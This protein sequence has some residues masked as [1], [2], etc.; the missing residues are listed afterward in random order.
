M[1]NKTTF[2]KQKSS[3][4]ESAQKYLCGNTS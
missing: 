4:E 3:Q 1:R 2:R